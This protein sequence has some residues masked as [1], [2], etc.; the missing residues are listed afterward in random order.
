MIRT[1]F[2]VDKVVV[3]LFCLYMVVITGLYFHMDSRIKILQT[4][5][6]SSLDLFK[7]YSEK[8][9]KQQ[10]DID[11]LTNRIDHLK[12][13]IDSLDNSL[14]TKLGDIFELIKKNHG[15][16]TKASKP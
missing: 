14:D 7:K 11:N 6:S 4:I 10:V 8:D 2:I 13:K 1:D 3:Y 16:G 12:S 9:I 15:G 5:Q